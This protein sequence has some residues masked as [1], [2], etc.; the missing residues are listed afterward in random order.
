M[1][2]DSAAQAAPGLSPE[3]F[4]RQ[5]EVSSRAILDAVPDPVFV[6]DA[7]SGKLTAKNA[8]AA[9]IAGSLSD[10]ALE[11]GELFSELDLAAVRKAIGSYLHTRMRQPRRPS[12]DG[13]ESD[14]ILQ[15]YPLEGDRQLVVVV[16]LLTRR[17]AGEEQA[18][19]LRDALDDALH[20]PLTRLPNRRLF[21][22]RLQRA[23]DRAK[24]TEYLFATLFLDLDRFKEINDQ[25]GH[26]A[27]DQTLVAV[28]HRLLEAVRSQD[29]VARRDGDEFMILLD[30]LAHA[31]DAMT[32]TQ[33]ILDHLRLPLDA[34]AKAANVGEPG[35]TDITA[36]IGVALPGQGNDRALGRAVDF[37]GGYGDVSSQGIGRRDLRGLSKRRRRQRQPARYEKA[38]AEVSL[39]AMWPET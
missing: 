12:D 27:G 20:D 39:D 4:S 36:S 33:R 26:L 37:A 24:R 28:A 11:L 9:E 13:Q 10:R 14:A 38:A 2:I 1:A 16:R 32:V 18:S 15:I 35:Q 31:D 6:L 22:R 23:I 19:P 5:D 21:E 34:A 30:D 3:R 25:F 29:M 8:A 17:D 7:D